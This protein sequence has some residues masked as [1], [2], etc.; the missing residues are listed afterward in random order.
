MIEISRAQFH[1][2]APSVSGAKLKRYAKDL[3]DEFDRVASERLPLEDY[4]IH[5]DI[6]EGSIKGKGTILATVAALYFG[7]GHFGGFVQGLREISGL[8]KGIGDSLINIAPKKLHVPENA[9]RSKYRDSGT[10]SQLERLFEAVRRGEIDPAEATKRAIELMNEADSE[11]P[12]KFVDDL[13]A[14]INDIKKYPEQ[15]ELPLPIVSPAIE[16]PS[17][18]RNRRKGQGTQAVITPSTKLRVEVWRERKNG[19]TLV[20]IIPI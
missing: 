8:A 15:I 7:I 16:I 3:F 5:L 19:K 13:G 1:L 17:P 14:A 9:L 6:E 2:D 20:R 18:R 11:L 4:A 12:K 10:I